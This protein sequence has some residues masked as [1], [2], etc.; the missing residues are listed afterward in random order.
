MARR[1]RP[2]VPPPR[3]T[4][5]APQAIATATAPIDVGSASRVRVLGRL[6][7]EWLARVAFSPDGRYLAAGTAASTYLYDAITLA[8]LGSYDQSD[9]AFVGADRIGFRTGV[10]RLADHA[11]LASFDEPLGERFAYSPDGT[12]VVHELSDRMIEVRTLGSP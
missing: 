2:N 7:W 10:V 6:G 3:W 5:A 11:V 4:P 8:P 9:F 1:S 12:R